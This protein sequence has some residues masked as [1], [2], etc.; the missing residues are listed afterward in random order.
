MRLRFGIRYKLKQT[1]QLKQARFEMLL[2]AKEI[3]FIKGESLKWS[4]G[5]WWMV[6]T[7]EAEGADGE[8]EK[9]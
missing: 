1:L 9:V 3:G 4:V 6:A 7:C 2:K 8:K 5:G